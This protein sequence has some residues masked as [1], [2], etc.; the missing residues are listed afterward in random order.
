MT[1]IHTSE[2]TNFEDNS[3]DF[4]YSCYL[5]QHLTKEETLV[6]F[7]EWKRI[8]KQGQIIRIS[9]PDFFLISSKYLHSKCNISDINQLLKGNQFI[10]FLY[11]Q[12]LL[13]QAGFYAVKRFDV[14]RFPPPREDMSLAEIN[15][16]SVSLNVEAYG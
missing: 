8:L 15:G 5:I 4:I 7:K 14:D 2:P 9:V 11:I 16:E 12:K 10:D 6:L 13:V 1:Y 3:I